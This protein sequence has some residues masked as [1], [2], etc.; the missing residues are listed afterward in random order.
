MSVILCD[1]IPLKIYPWILQLINNVNL[2]NNYAIE[3]MKWV[4]YEAV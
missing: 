4:V 3:L 1:K 2:Q